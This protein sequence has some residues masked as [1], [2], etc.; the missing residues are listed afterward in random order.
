[1]RSLRRYLQISLRATFAVITILAILL[2]LQVRKANNQRRAVEKITALGGSVG[3]DYQMNNRTE[4]SAPVWLRELVGDDHFQ[5]VERAYFY[6]KPLKDSDLD[7]V[8]QLPNLNSLFIGNAPMIT[9][10]VMAHVSE[11]GELTE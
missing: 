10:E 9:D 4:P 3:Y 7:F 5:S 11:A 1:R 6:E 8:G 2:G